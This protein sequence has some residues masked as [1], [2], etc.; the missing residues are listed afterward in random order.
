LTIILRSA[1]APVLSRPQLHRVF[2]ASRSH[3]AYLRAKAELADSDEDDGPPDDDAW[4][5]EDLTV[6]VKLYARL[7]DREQLIALIFEVIPLISFHS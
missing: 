1:E 3:A 4:L 5:F 7:H 6:L 2:R